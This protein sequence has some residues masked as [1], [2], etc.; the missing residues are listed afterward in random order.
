MLS[1]VSNKLYV[2]GLR[3][4]VTLLFAGYTESFTDYVMFYRA[5]PWGIILILL[6]IDDMIIT[7]RDHTAIASLKQHLFEATSQESVWD[8]NSWPFAL[9]SRHW[10]CLLFSGLSTLVT[11]VYFRHFWACYSSRPFS[12]CFFICICSHGTEHKASQGRWWWS[13]YHIPHSIGNLL[14]LLSVF[15]L[16]GQIFLMWYMF[17]VSL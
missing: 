14:V 4:F 13:S 10:G 15:S 5:S 8:E 16:L 1:M 17:W 3:S 6:Y 12:L 7:V 9:F 2:L 11:E